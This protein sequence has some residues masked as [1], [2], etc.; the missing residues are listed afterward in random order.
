MPELRRLE[1]RIVPAMERIT[2]FIYHQQLPVFG[3]ASVVIMPQ[4][5]RPEPDLPKLTHTSEG[6]QM[7]LSAAGSER[8]VDKLDHPC[9][10]VGINPLDLYVTSHVA[11]LELVIAAKA[12]L[13]G[14]SDVRPR[15]IKAYKAI[16]SAEQVSNIASVLGEQT[17]ISISEV[18]ATFTQDELERLNLLR[19]GIGVALV[20]MSLKPSDVKVFRDSAKHEALLSLNKYFAGAAHYLT[21][22]AFRDY[23]IASKVSEVY[24]LEP[25]ILEVAGS[26]PMNVTYLFGK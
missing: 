4:D 15:V 11:Q 21:G 24:K 23:E 2:T 7:Q 5:N 8:W 25:P 10:A 17:G 19:Y 26:S 14:D 16:Q 1:D 18:M 22:N 9:V 13:D 20:S 12:S 6:P 3:D